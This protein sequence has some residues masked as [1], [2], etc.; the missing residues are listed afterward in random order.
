MLDHALIITLQCRR[1]SENDKKD[2]CS[3]LCWSITADEKIVV[4]DENQK[5]NEPPGSCQTIDSR[6]SSQSILVILH[7]A[8]INI[9]CI[10]PRGRIKGTAR[11]IYSIL[12]QLQGNMEYIAALGQ[13]GIYCPGTRYIAR[14]QILSERT[15]N[16][17]GKGK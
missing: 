4:E 14:V 10:P 7:M 9:I 16:I 6:V 1:P 11:T 8:S 13:Y 5:E 3:K 17:C 12:P 15:D 2:M